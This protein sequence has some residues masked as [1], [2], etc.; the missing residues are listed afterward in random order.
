MKKQSIQTL[1]SGFL[2]FILIG[3]SSSG[4]RAHSAEEPLDLVEETDVEAKEDEE[5]YGTISEPQILKLLSAEGVNPSKD[6]L[7]ID[8][9]IKKLGVYNLKIRLHPE[10]EATFRVWVVKNK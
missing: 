8:E 7:I 4:D 9:P 3:W 1:V 5:L 10:V 2:L 6:A